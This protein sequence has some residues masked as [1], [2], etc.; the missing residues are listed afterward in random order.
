M[1]ESKRRPV[2]LCIKS[3]RLSPWPPSVFK[4]Y[5]YVFGYM[6]EC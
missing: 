5:R 6:V 2:Y 3:K 4:V 1:I